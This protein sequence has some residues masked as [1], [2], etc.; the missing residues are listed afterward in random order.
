MGWLTD[1]NI[2]IRSIINGEEEVIYVSWEE[3]FAMAQHL[4]K[5]NGDKTYA[6]AIAKYSRE[7][8]KEKPKEEPKKPVAKPSPV[9]KKN[10]D[11]RS[12]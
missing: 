6:L 7:K 3:F 8:P 9:K 11:W 5:P 12:L 1:K 10:F 4:D 2:P